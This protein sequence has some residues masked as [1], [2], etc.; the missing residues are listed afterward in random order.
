MPPGEGASA[1][2][3]AGTNAASRGAQGSRGRPAWSLPP[4]ARRRR[5][6]TVSHRC[7]PTQPPNAKTS[8]ARSAA[9]IA[10][11]STPVGVN[12]VSRKKLVDLAPR[13]RTAVSEWRGVHAR[14]QA[15][16]IWHHRKQPAAGGKHAPYF[17]QESARIVRHLQRMHQHARDRPPNQAAAIRFHR[18]ARR[19]PG[20]WSATSRRPARPA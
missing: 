2:S 8:R 17:A 7:A 11:R 12:Q 18:P 14:P 16:P 5:A 1:G 20:A 10:P 4:D 9:R 3:S 6:P 13:I 15:A 19:M